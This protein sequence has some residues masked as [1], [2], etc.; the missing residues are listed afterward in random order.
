MRVGVGQSRERAA[1][2]GDVNAML[3]FQ[4]ERGGDMMKHCQKMKQ[5]Q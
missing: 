4:L 2:T 5:M 3:Q 1:D